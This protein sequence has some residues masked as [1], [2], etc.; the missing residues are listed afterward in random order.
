MYVLFCLC[1]IRRGFR[2][3]LDGAVEEVITQTPS[4][5]GRA[6]SLTVSPSSSFP[7]SVLNYRMCLH[8]RSGECAVVTVGVS[9]GVSAQHL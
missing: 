6:L 8:L 1:A 2:R 7:P 4:R 3:N 9:S 5:P